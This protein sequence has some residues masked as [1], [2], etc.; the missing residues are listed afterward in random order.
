MQNCPKK[1]M[2]EECPISCVDFHQDSCSAKQVDER[3]KLIADGLG[4]IPHQVHDTWRWY[5]ARCSLTPGKPVELYI[6]DFTTR[7]DW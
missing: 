3:K 4:M 5:A 6:D 7:L 2:S 1:N